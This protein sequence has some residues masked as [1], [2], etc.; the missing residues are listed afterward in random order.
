MSAGIAGSASGLTEIMIISLLGSLMAGYFI[1]NDFESKTIHD[2]VAC[3]NGRISVV[4]SKAFVFVLIVILLLL[5]YAAASLIGFGTGAEFTKPFGVSAF[6]SILANEAGLGV[7]ASSVGKI[8]VVSLV[9]MLVYAAR[10]SICLPI[11]FK[12]RKPVVVMAIGFAASFLIDLLAGLTKDVPILGNIISNTP[13]SL[14]AAVTME[15]GTETLIKAAGI[16]VL[17]YVI[18]SAVTYVLFKRAEIK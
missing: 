11:A 12:V 2:A 10:L 6:L 14:T 9:T 16:S 1:C 5:P 8:L 13:Y 3:G 18:M 17:F 7:T 4:V 15:A